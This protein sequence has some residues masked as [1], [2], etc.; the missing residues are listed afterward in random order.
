MQKVSRAYTRASGPPNALRGARLSHPLPNHSSSLKRRASSG[1]AQGPAPRCARPL[2]AARPLR[3]TALWS[4]QGSPRPCAPEAPG[5]GARP[6]P[7]GDSCS[8][9]P[10]SSRPEAHTRQLPTRLPGVC[11]PRLLL[12]PLPHTIRPV[13]FTCPPSWWCLHPRTRCQAE[14]P[15]GHPPMHPSFSRPLLHSPQKPPSPLLSSSPALQD[16][17]SEV[18]WTA[19]SSRHGRFTLKTLL[20]LCPYSGR[21]LHA[22]SWGELPTPPPRVRAL[23]SGSGRLP[24]RRWASRC[25]RTDRGLGQWPALTRA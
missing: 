25:L 5:G 17:A 24:G 12:D 1:K 8:R 7:G 10:V 20:N 23:R 14:S 19:P 18:S 3:H 4:V 16:P 22:G 13:T 21:Y 11:S 15:G 6:C 2:G 9:G